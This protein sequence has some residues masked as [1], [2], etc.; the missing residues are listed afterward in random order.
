MK[1][2]LEPLIPE[3]DYCY[4]YTGRIKINNKVIGFDGE[5]RPA[6]YYFSPETKTCPFWKSVGGGNAFCAHTNKT[7]EYGEIDNM[8]WDQIKECD[9]NRSDEEEVLLNLFELEEGKVCH[10]ILGNSHAH[11]KRKPEFIESLLGILLDSEYNEF[12]YDGVTY[13]LSQTIIDELN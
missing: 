10:P 5:L 7:S 4:S 13:T 11:A 12:V 9:V 2:P 1:T 3:G 8:V 6:S